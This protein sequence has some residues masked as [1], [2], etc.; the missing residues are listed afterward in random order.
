MCD[1]VAKK[2]GCGDERARPD[3]RDRFGDAHVFLQ[4]TS[5]GSIGASSV[6]HTL[7]REGIVLSGIVM[8]SHVLRAAFRAI[9]D[10]VTNR[11]Q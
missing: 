3:S 6:A 4:G 5:A 11:L 1:P 8:D 10:W 9:I 2:K 7:Q